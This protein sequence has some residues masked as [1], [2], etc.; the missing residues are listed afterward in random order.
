MRRGIAIGGALS[1]LL[2]GTPSRAQSPAQ[3]LDQNWVNVCAGAVPGT[4]FYDRCQEILNAGPGSANRRSSAATGNNLETVGAAGRNGWKRDEEPRFEITE[5]RANIFLSSSTG[6]EGRRASE[7]EHGFDAINQTVLAGL[8]YLAT[9]SNVVG[10]GLSYTANSVTFDRTVGDL[11]SQRVGVT[12]FWNHALPLSFGF[13]SRVGYSRTHHEIARNIDYVI[14]L[15]S[16][17]PTEETRLISSLASAVVRGHEVA[18]AADLSADLAARALTVLPHVGVEL[19]RTTINPYTE[20]DES[21]LAMAYDRQTV[22]STVLLAGLS[23][24]VA[25]SREWGVLTPQV[26]ADVLHEF[27]NDERAIVARFVQDP[28]GYQLEIPTAAP[29]RDFFLIGAA[30]VVVLPGGFSGYLD[31]RGTLGHAQLRDQLFSVGLR[32]RL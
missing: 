22:R 13:E 23:A 31:V 2:A 15:N 9:S 17:Q 30:V 4:P 28:G 26:R 10:L 21:G 3:E 8:D 1:L 7:R 29:D 5:G 16:G 19:V 27:A 24:S 18:A 11:R 32:A 6:W 20:T 14:V 25:V 12:G